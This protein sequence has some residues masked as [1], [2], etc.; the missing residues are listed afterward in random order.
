MFVSL[1]TSQSIVD[2]MPTVAWHSDVNRIL[3]RFVKVFNETLSSCDLQCLSKAGCEALCT[4][5]LSSRELKIQ[6]LSK[7]DALSIQPLFTPN[8]FSCHVYLYFYL[9]LHPLR[10]FNV[11]SVLYKDEKCTTWRTRTFEALLPYDKDSTSTL[12][13]PTME[14]VDLNEISLDMLE[15]EFR[16][17]KRTILPDS[18]PSTTDQ[19]SI[20][21]GQ[22][23]AKS[24]ASVN[25]NDVA[26]TQ[27]K[28][29]EKLTPPDTAA[30]NAASSRKEIDPDA[31]KNTASAQPKP[32]QTG[33]KIDTQTDSSKPDPQSSGQSQTQAGSI[34]SWLLGIG[35][36]GL[37]GGGLYAWHQSRKRASQ[38]E[39]AVQS[40]PI[41][42]MRENLHR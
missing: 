42:Q 2:L 8:P 26:A 39:N 32:D 17:L 25:Q 40:Y 30:A 21:T 35:G 37:A 34:S 28:R 10:Q 4:S 3:D 5:K 15:N 22:N 31:N 14:M 23:A 36:V 6:F 18:Q 16:T 1:N 24:S 41:R 11:S 29:D 19:P 9:Y 12:H 20:A 38:K 13:L 27:T 33:G 7:D